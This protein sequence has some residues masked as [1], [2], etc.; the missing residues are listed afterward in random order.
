MNI[1]LI[2]AQDSNGGIGKGGNLP[3]HIP[4]DL[5]NFKQLT[6]NSTVVM[7]RKT[8]DSLPVKPLPKRRNIVLSKSK[9]VSAETF[10]SY[11]ECME[12]LKKNNLKKI[13]IIGGRSVYNL[14]FDDADFLHITKVNLLEPDVNE[15]FP[16]STKEINKKFQQ[17]FEKQICPKAVYTLWRK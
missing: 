4:E 11:E 5:K 9:Q 13:F 7:G 1:H 3:W 6:I 2:W 17:I 10:K 14:F 15:F 12:H 8:W 16:V